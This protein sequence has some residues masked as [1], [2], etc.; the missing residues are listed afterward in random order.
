MPVKRAGQIHLLPLLNSI[1]LF[2]FIL[3]LRFKPEIENQLVSS[4]PVV[5]VISL[6]GGR[7]AFAGDG[8]G[9]GTS[10]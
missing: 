10:P 5:L 8:F 9:P 4:E 7:K 2:L 3:L 6:E 1:S